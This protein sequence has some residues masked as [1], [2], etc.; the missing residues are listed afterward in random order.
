M[1]NVNSDDRMS[2]PNRVLDLLNRSMLRTRCQGDITSKVADKKN[3]QNNNRT[4]SND[5]HNNGRSFHTTLEPFATRQG[6]DCFTIS[7]PVGSCGQEQYLGSSGTTATEIST[8]TRRTDCNGTMGCPQ[9]CLFFIRYT[10]PP[11]HLPI[12]PI[13][14]FPPPAP[15]FF[16]SSASHTRVLYPSHLRSIP[17]PLPCTFPPIN[18][19]A[20]PRNNSQFSSTFSCTLPSSACPKSV[21]LSPSLT[22]MRRV[23]AMP[24]DSISVFPHPV[25]LLLS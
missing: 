25:G 9:R 21:R 10:L 13:P 23:W 1:P 18:F 24:R 14:P 8:T 5:R 19:Q 2:I 17:R 3:P 15:F 16:V 6:K 22:D 7:S 4:S 12:P 20:L 11:L